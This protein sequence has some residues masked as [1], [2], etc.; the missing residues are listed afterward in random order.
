MATSQR[1]YD[2]RFFAHLDFHMSHAVQWLKLIE[3]DTLMNSFVPGHV[4]V[5]PAPWAIGTT[6]FWNNKKRQKTKHDD[7]KATDDGE[8]NDEAFVGPEPPEYDGDMID[9]DSDGSSHGD[10]GNSE[11]HAIKDSYLSLIYIYRVNF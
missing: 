2:Y 1:F 4:A 6:E 8:E 10:D 9:G 7:D 3:D 11:S 5:R